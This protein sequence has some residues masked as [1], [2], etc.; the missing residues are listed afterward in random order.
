[1]VDNVLLQ[2]LEISDATLAILTNNL[3]WANTVDR[4]FENKLSTGIGYTLTIRKPNRYVTTYGPGLQIQGIER[5][6]RAGHGRHAGA[7][8]FMFSIANLTMVVR[9]FAAR[10]LDPAGETLANAIDAQVASNYSS[11]WN[12]V[13]IPG[14]LP[15]SFASLS[16]VAKRM[17]KLAVGQS[18]RTLV[19]NPDA[20]WSVAAG[21][22]TLYVQS[23]AEPAL[24]GFVTN[25][26]NLKVYM[27]QNAPVHTNGA[28][29]GSFSSTTGLH[30]RRRRRQRRG[31][32]GVNPDY[33][34]LGGLGDGT[35]EHRRH[36]HD[37][38]R[39][40]G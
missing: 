21:V 23:V 4:R 30:N 14:T 36:V 11:I 35:V 28:F 9:E 38:G 8:H 32:I 19:L 17:D 27:N 12:L 10:Y 1:M 40:F 29:G 13:G 37:F 18:G 2:P 3:V 39:P 33:Q 20:Y 22:T 26:A 7:C 15:N 25:L 34:R 31:P 16:L 5:T 6:V 24:K